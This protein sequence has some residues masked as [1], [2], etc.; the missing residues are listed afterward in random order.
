MANK[1][2]KQ[3]STEIT[4]LQPDDWF[5]VQQD[6]DNVTGKAKASNVFAGGWTPLGYSLTSLTALGNR[7][8]TAV[9]SGTDTTG[10]TSVGQ[11]LKLP[12]TVTAPTQ[13]ADLES[14]S[15]QYFSKTSPTGL[16]FTTTF[17]CSAWIKLES[18][19]VTCGIIA[20]RNV[21]TEGW[22]FRINTD[23][24][25]QLMGLRIA[26]NNKS[27]SSY[28][29]VPLNKWVHVAATMDM[30]VG[31]TSAQK[32]WIDGVE[33]G[34]AYTLT[35]TAAVLVQG[36]TALVVGADKSAGTSPFDGKIAQAAVFSAQLSD[37][38]VKAMM[39]QG[40]TGSE[41]N[42]VSAYSL[43]GVITDLSANANDLTANGGAL[44]T[45][46]DTPFT[47]PVT[48]TSVTAG[49]TNYGIITAQ[50]FS[51]NTTYTIQVPEGETLPTTGGIGTVSYSAQATPYGFPK[52]KSKWT[53]LIPKGAAESFTAT[54][55]A[56]LNHSIF[57]PVGDWTIGWKA[58]CSASPDTSP[59]S[60]RTTIITLSSTVLSSTTVESAD[61]TGSVGGRPGVAATDFTVKA[62]I[63]A[64]EEISLSASATYTIYGRTNTGSPTNNAIYGSVTDS[65]RAVIKLVCAYL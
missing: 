8:Y 3:L 12:R 24:T 25:V 13:C 54:T 36:T 42:L 58:G 16:S 2:I 6:A 35:G 21:D 62:T 61:L 34:R 60:S 45:N 37:A 57:V 41:T 11:R 51:T 20:R 26:A 18:Y 1:T 31:D 43:N 17:T 52:Q 23:G 33:V 55:F 19:G 49:T 32:I 39:N 10:V 30:A 14:G 22:S 56:T 7:S 5:V 44:A 27:I 15:S 65:D 40:L 4:T 9:V 47:N 50:T 63:N 46:A 28:Q 64:E 53:I 38:T 48:G 29:S 59:A